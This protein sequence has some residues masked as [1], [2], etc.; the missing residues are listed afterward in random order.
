MDK[1][2]LPLASL[3]EAC[4]PINKPNDDI[5]SSPGFPCLR[6]IHSCDSPPLQMASSRTENIRPLPKTVQWSPWWMLYC[7]GEHLKHS[8]LPP[9]AT[10]GNVGKTSS[11]L[12]TKFTTP[13]REP[14]FNTIRRDCTNSPARV[15]HGTG[16][17]PRPLD[18]NPKPCSNLHEG[19]G[20]DSRA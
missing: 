12:H 4:V 5:S 1:C 10:T 20:I 11:F 7:N 15:L 17:S 18:E 16:H 9:L 6:A 13:A 14:R 2:I 19:L 8:M 3:F